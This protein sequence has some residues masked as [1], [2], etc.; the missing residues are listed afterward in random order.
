MKDTRLRELTRFK[1]SKVTIA[2]CCRNERYPF[3]G[4]DTTLS[5]IANLLVDLSRNERY[6][7]EGIDTLQLLM[8]LN[9]A[10]FS[11]RRNI[12]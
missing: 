10:I 9:L 5:Y 2:P 3:E 7:F 11:Q 4:I 12:L 1:A 8:L 6:P